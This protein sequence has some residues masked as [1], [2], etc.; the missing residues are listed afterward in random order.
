MLAT[1][2]FTGETAS[3]WQQVNF[4]TPVAI[5][6]GTTYVASYL[7]PQGHYAADG[8]YFASSGVDNGVLHALSNSTGGGDGVYLYTTSGGY[9]SNSYNSTNYWVDVVFSTTVTPAVI[10]T[11]PA[12]GSTEVSTSSPNITA[13]FNEAVQSGSISFVLTDSGG[14]TVP[15]S[16]SYNTTTNTATFTPTVA[17]TGGKTYTATVSGAQDLAN[18]V[19]SA[20]YSWTFT[21][22]SS[23]SSNATIWSSTAAPANPSANDSGSVELG[24]K[25]YSDVSGFITGVRFYKGSGNTGTH[26]GHLWT[27]TGTLLATATFTGE[28]AS[29]WQQV[30]FATP[31]AITA[32]TTYVASYLAPQG[33]YAA[34]GGYF[35]SSGVDNG[36]LHALSNS[37]GGGDGVYLY[38]TSGGYPSN[39]YNSTNYWVDV[40]FSTTVTPAVISTTPAAGSTE[41]STSSPN[42][43]A[44]FNEAV[45]SG[46]ISFVLT[47]S[48]GNTV[49]TSLS[50]NTTTNTATFTPTVALT[51]GKTYTATV[52]GAQDLAN[53]VMSAP[54]SWTF[55]TV[56]STS[57]NATIWSSTAAPANPSANDSGSVE[58]GVKFYSDVSG[59]ITGV[60]FYKGS[61]NTGTH[62]GHLWTSTGTLLATATFTG[63]TASGWQQ[64][65]FATPVA[66]TA[67]T[68]YV[69]SY[70]APQGHYAADGGYF[71]SSGVD[72][73]VLHAAV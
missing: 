69:A 72:N 68:T 32:G 39:S 4:A 73:G 22:V 29:G 27:S 11:T 14:N 26:V 55:T 59:F 61:G 33:H 64:V 3:G 54:Y 1:A 38:T 43:T 66:I 16:L 50:Y 41:V 35:A 24:V 15:T 45:Q 34:D 42:I 63:E 53:D 13:T 49:P 56:S 71:A 25:F 2:T 58:L 8:G 18:D 52:S 28:T 40:V 20:P 48:G 6:A 9:P 62:V 5:T 65:N 47:D 67:G 21:T 51:G 36:V 10:S 17:L 23:T 31:V 7:A 46:S 30:N 70:L 44:T 12:A 57:S 19:M 60:R 37:T